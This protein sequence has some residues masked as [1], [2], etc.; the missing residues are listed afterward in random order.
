VSDLPDGVQCDVRW[1]LQTVGGE[2]VS[3]GVEDVFVEAEA[4]T[5]VVLLDFDEQCAQLGAENLL[6]FAEMWNGEKR[7]S[8]NFASFVRPKHLALEDPGLELVTE[9]DRS[10]SVRATIT[11]ERPA[12]WV[13]PELAGHK[14]SVPPRYSDRFF[15]MRARTSETVVITPSEL[16]VATGASDGSEEEGGHSADPAR[17]PAGSASKSPAGEENYPHVVVRSLIDTYRGRT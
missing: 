3:F 5:A 15:C 14:G 8:R 9:R 16:D 17:R 2:D 12:L 10:G 6:F 13:W 7:V 11:V 1:W 4:N